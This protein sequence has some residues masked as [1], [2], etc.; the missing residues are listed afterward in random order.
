MIN[1]LFIFLFNF[2]LKLNGLL[3][4]GRA[5]V[6]LLFALVL[7]LFVLVAPLVAQGKK[8][9]IQFRNKIEEAG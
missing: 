4:R 9:P 5:I 7:L 3:L 1:L 8:G 6:C 2:T